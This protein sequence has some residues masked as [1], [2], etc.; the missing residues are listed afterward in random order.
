MPLLVFITDMAVGGRQ[1]FCFTLLNELAKQGVD[2]E[3][4]ISYGGGQYLEKLDP[5]IKLYIAGGAIR[6]SIRRAHHFVGRHPNAAC[7]CLS[8]EITCVLL[9]LKRLGIIKNPIYHRESMDVSECGL[10]WRWLIKLLYPRLSGL[11]ATSQFTIDSFSRYYHL[12]QPVAIIRNP[13]LFDLESGS[14]KVLQKKLLSVGRLDPIKGLDRLLEAAKRHGRGW[15][16]E[17]WGDGELMSE[18]RTLKHDMELDETVKLCGYTNDVQSIYQSGGIL[19]VSSY[20]EGLP[21]VIIEG[22]CCGCRVIVPEC[23]YASVELLGE[24]G[25]TIGVVHD[26]FEENLFTTADAVFA[27]PETIWSDARTKLSNM[28]N[29]SN[30]AKRY[31]NFIREF[32]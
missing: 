17:I 5:K 10:G 16:L 13:C 24:L 25:L 29:V 7:L 22:I 19:V 1:R 14:A 11:I 9:F 20:H 3:L 27:S 18:L 8:T 15:K 32:K 6:K 21:N 2:C 4:Y 30:V 31:I 12:C 28:T 23:L 26:N